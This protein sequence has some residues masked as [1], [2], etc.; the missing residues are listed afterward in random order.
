M[1]SL[2]RSVPSISIRD[3]SAALTAKTKVI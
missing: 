2:F 1:F 3:F